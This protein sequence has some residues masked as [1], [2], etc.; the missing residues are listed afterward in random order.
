MPCSRFAAP[1]QETP[2]SEDCRVPVRGSSRV[3]FVAA[4]SARSWTFTG[5]LACPPVPWPE[6]GAATAYVTTPPPP[7]T[8]APSVSHARRLMPDGLYARFP[9]GPTRPHPWKRTI[10]V[11]SDTPVTQATLRGSVRS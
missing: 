2:S 8:T 10:T 9:R 7:R 5:R 6:D 11:T 1:V 3:P 4:F